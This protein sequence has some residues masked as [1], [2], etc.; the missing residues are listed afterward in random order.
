MMYCYDVANI[1]WIKEDKDTFPFSAFSMNP[2]IAARDLKGSDKTF[3]ENVK[4]IWDVI[5]PDVEFN[6]QTVG[7]TADDI[8]KDAYA[9]KAMIDDPN[10]KL[11]VKVNCFPEGYKAMKV[12][13]KEGFNITATA[14]ASVNQALLAAECGAA[15][16]AVYV[17]RTDNISGDGIKVI[18][19][20]R[21]VY[22]AQG[23]K[24][25]R[26]SAASLKTARHVED[27]A[28]AGADL[29]AISHDVLK[30]I[31]THPLTEQCIASF[32]S[33]WEGL[34]GKGKMI[35]NL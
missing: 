14:I 34:Y 19:G 28:L 20:I 3:A 2:S 10:N 12:L 8:I 6:V 21:K 7:V 15:W 33:D 16:T 9:I 24:H 23:I 18:E 27:A 30:A 26:L 35:W 5:G 31:S 17:G 29:V 32:T 25:T 22:D 1:N 13:Y 4:E 11:Q